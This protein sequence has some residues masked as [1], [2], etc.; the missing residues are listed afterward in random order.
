MV[1]NCLLLMSVFLSTEVRLVRGGGVGRSWLFLW[2]RQRDV[3]QER[4]LGWAPVESVNFSPLPPVS[5]VKTCEDATSIGFPC[6]S[7][8]DVIGM[9]TLW[10][11]ALVYLL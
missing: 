11:L 7:V 9:V 8:W 1:T 5:G 6:P 10:P 2:G 3:L 4:P